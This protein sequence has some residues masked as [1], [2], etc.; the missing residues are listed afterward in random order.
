MLLLKPPNKYP[1]M[2]RFLHTSSAISMQF[3]L[4]HLVFFGTPDEVFHGPQEGLVIHV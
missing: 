1:T 2:R 3:D 4:G